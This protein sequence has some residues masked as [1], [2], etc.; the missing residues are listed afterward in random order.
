VFL[1]LEARKWLCR[2]G[3]RGFRQQFPGILSWQR[4]TERFRR[5]IFFRHRDGISRR[6]LGRR[7]GIG[8]ATIER[9]YGDNLSRVAK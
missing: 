1:I 9:K 8:S 4:A 7:E 5:M 6:R 2:A 3:G